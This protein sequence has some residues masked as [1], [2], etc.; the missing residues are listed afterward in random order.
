MLV[1]WARVSM[2]L[3]QGPCSVGWSRGMGGEGA[4]KKWQGTQC[5]SL[6]HHVPT[7]NSKESSNSRFKIHLLKDHQI[8]I[9][10]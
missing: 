7:R 5:L 3:P 6:H 8:K 10:G 4:G 1:A 2:C 9:E